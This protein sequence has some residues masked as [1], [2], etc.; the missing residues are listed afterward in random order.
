M[1]AKNADE[2]WQAAKEL[3]A[4]VPESVKNGV[5]LSGKDQLI[6][7]AWRA[8]RESVNNYLDDIANSAGDE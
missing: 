5:M 8:A 3:D 6:Y 1:N 7:N 4:F 2:V